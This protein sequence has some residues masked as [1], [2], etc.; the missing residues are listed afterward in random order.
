MY[1]TLNMSQ[2]QYFKHVTGTVLQ[3]RHRYRNLNMSQ[4]E[5]FKYVSGRVP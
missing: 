2:V 4:V 5:C 3:T 1:S